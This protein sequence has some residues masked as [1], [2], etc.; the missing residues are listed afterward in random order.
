MDGWMDELT[1]PR[2][3]QKPTPP[4]FYHAHDIVSPWL[5]N[6]CHVIPA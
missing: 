4:T 5:V 2:E 3:P 1:H 6:S